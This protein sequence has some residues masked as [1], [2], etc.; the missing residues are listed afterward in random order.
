MTHAALCA[1]QPA[2]KVGSAFI[3][4]IGFVAVTKD[5]FPGKDVC[6]LTR[7]TPETSEK[8]R[9]R[10]RWAD[11][12]RVTAGHYRRNYYGRHGAS[13]LNTKFN[14]GRP[15]ALWTASPSLALAGSYPASR[16]GRK[17]NG[18][19]LKSYLLALKCSRIRRTPNVT[20]SRSWSL[21]SVAPTHPCELH[22]EPPLTGLWTKT[23]KGLLHLSHG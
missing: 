16:A 9:P 14:C 1:A 6:A 22:S 12:L 23:R 10:K 7:G 20:Q 17:A 11:L 8:R 3:V 4:A 18:R 19:I 15:A 5:G 13:T 2:M 21:S